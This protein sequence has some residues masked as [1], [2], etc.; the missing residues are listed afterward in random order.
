M[1]GSNLK[2]DINSPIWT[3][4]FWPLADD[5]PEQVQDSSATHTLLKTPAGHVL[6]F[7]DNENA[8]MLSLEHN[9]GA[10]LFMD[11]E[12]SLELTDKNGATV[13]LNSAD[14]VLTLKDTH[15][16]ELTL[17][18][19]GSLLKDSHGNKVEMVASGVTVKGNKVVIA[20]QQVMLG[21]DGGEPVLKG[22]SFL[23]FFMTHVHPVPGLGSSLPPV[24]QGEVAALSMKVKTL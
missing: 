14:N 13:T 9:Q 16:N 24:P 19:K 12:G 8:P 1:S 17:N 11:E 10:K 3:G 6:H 4:G 15:G 7:D 21:G 20:G 18:S 5:V 2:A 22:Q 23:N